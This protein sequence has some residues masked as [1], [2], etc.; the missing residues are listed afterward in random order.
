MTRPDLSRRLVL[1]E[2]VRA[3]D[4]AGGFR[5]TWQARGVLWAQIQ[6]GGGRQRLRDF[7]T[8][9]GVTSRIIVRAAPDGAPSRPRPDQRFRE[10]A[11]LFRILAVAETDEDGRY[12]TCFAREEVSA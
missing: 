1:E 5:D 3:P 9:S 8:I 4:G 6:A 11:R 7:T 10:G 12:L 2:A